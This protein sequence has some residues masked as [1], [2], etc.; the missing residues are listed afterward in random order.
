MID[1]DHGPGRT[2][3]LVFGD[4]LHRQD[5]PDRDIDR[6]AD[7]HD[8]E[9]GLGH[10]PLLDAL[11]DALELRQPR[12]RRRIFRIG[13]PGRLADH[14]ADRP[15]DRSLGDEIDVGVRVLLPALA[16]D[17]PTGL[18]AAGIV[19]GARRR[20]AERNALAVLAVFGQRAVGETLLVAQLDARQ[21]EHA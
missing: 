4:L 3:R 15:P 12:R 13:L 14:V 7:L 2:K 16:L 11:E 21:I 6:V 10:G 1:L 20:I 19:A 17:D 5:R 9:L 18:A 8:L